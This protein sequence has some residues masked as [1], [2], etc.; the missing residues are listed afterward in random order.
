MRVVL[1]TNLLIS[2]FVFPG[3]APELVY[4]AAIQHRIQLVSS[5][6]LLAEFG[7]VLSEKFDWEN[8]LVEE[9]VAQLVR[10]GTIVRPQERISVIGDDP[11][12]DR[13][14][15]AAFRSEAEAIVSGDR[16]L[17]RLGTW[18]GIRIVRATTLLAELGIDA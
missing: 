17:L 5:P 11:A 18:E 14:L 8:A 13:V 12:D 1:D 15:E 7:R 9:A 10:I 2:A 3:G 4:R 16:H 6:P